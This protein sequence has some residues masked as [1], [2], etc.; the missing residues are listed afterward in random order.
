MKS[1]LMWKFHHLIRLIK[2]LN[3]LQISKINKQMKTKSRIPLK[4]EMTVKCI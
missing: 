3:E 2:L 4:S 1:T